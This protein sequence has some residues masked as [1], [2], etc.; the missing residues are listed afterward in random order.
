MPDPTPSPTPKPSAT[1]RPT[2]VPDRRPPRSPARRPKPSATPKP[3]ATP[4]PSATPKPTATPKPKPSPTPVPDSIPIREARDTAIG[5]SVT[6]T[7]TVTVEPVGYLG[8]DVFVVQDGSGA[9]AVKAPAGDMA[10]ELA[11]GRIVTVTGELAAPY[12]NLEVRPRAR[13]DLAVIGQGGLP[14]PATITTSDLGEAIEGDLVSITGTIAEIDRGSAGTLTVTITDRD[15]DGKVYLHAPVGETASELARDQSV[16]VTGIAGQRAS[17]SGAADGYRVWPREDADIRIVSRP[18]KETARPDEP[19]GS[20]PPRGNKRPR[21][22]RIADA[23]F[24][25]EVTIVGTVTSAPGL[26]DSDGRRVTVEDGSGGILVRLPADSPVPAV[27]RRNP[28]LGRGR[29]VVRRASARG[30]RL[31]A[32]EGAA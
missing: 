2:P 11:R 28:G 21:K 26:I 13:E 24:G 14:E 31:S 7:G 4:K 25:E 22:V 10:S 5:E 15:G 29:H 8:K 20:K 23:A 30:R 16:R 12:G 32:R 1:P 17:R 9:V 19:G 3:T 27:G 6:V 18:P